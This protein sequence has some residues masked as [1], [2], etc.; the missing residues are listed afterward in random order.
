MCFYLLRFASS[1]KYFTKETK[2]SLLLLCIVC[3]CVCVCLLLLKYI[4]INK[5]KIK[6]NH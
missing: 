6:S 2:K 1:I 3:V 5:Y 4:F